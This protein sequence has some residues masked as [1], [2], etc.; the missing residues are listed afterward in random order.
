MIDE[1]NELV[2]K[3]VPFLKRG[4]SRRDF[5]K[6]CGLLAASLGLEA[7]F[8]P[9][10]AHALESGLRP[11]VIWLHFAECTGCTES[12]LRSASP[13]SIDALV[14]EAL[15]I[16]YHE[17]IMADYGGSAHSRL[18]KAVNDYK[19]EFICIC[20]GAIPT[21]KNG[22]YGM[23]G[24]RTML[25]LAKDVCPKAKAVISY[26][27]CASYGG[28]PAAIGG[29][30]G[31]KGVHAALGGSPTINIPGC[32]PNPF[33]LVS[34]IVNYLLMG[35]F[36]PI[37]AKGRPTSLYSLVNHTNC[38]YKDIVNQANCLRGLGCRGPETYNNCPSIKFNNGI[39]WPVS[40][41]SPCYGCSEPEFWDKGHFFNYSGTKGW[42]DGLK[43]Y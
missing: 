35:N 23:I 41:D 13:N 8:I 3:E 12:F 36:P 10:I 33:N 18:M 17:T 16:E 39:T 42:G 28:V 38:E 6:Y 4:I 1:R 14:L 2:D 34:T 21:A 22:I 27:T 37:D 20:E 5:M 31:A 9:K 43:K 15:S 19:G 7:S 32:P 26:G 40:E 29:L 11:P 25:Q 30:T 24:N